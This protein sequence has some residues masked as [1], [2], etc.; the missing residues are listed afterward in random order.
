VTYVPYDPSLEM[1]MKV[2]LGTSNRDLICKE[3]SPAEC[4]WPFAWFGNVS[5]NG[6]FVIRPT[7]ACGTPPALYR[8]SA[9]TPP[10]GLILSRSRPARRL[11]RR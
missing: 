5:A 2:P 4:S 3:S 10:I 9:G 8:S 11:P 7:T 1:P 6:L